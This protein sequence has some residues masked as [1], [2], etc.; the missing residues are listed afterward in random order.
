[1]L[2][3]LYLG[4]G[5]PGH[6]GSAPP[7]PGLVQEIP[8]ADGI[9]E[10]P[11]RREVCPGILRDSLGP[12]DDATG[13]RVRF[14]GEDTEA[15]GDRTLPPGP[16][17]P[18]TW[19]GGFQPSQPASG[20]PPRLPVARLE[21]RQPA[22][23]FPSPGFCLLCE[24]AVR[25]ELA[26]PGHGPGF[27]GHHLDASFASHVVPLET[28]AFAQRVSAELREAM[29]SAPNLASGVSKALREKQGRLWRPEVSG[30]IFSSIVEEN[31][32]GGLPGPWAQPRGLRETADARAGTSRP[33]LF[34]LAPVPYTEGL[35]PWR[36]PAQM[37]LTQAT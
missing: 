2:L 17:S 22:S 29:H 15:E 18:C 16:H 34:G 26:S 8:T 27:S 6:A 5:A 7:G 36:C 32:R 19:R 11:L 4:E 28:M 33:A 3:G 10:H 14:A 20:S 35:V 9:R 24:A 31:R 1:M 23:R 37:D 30:S 12:P 13:D 21:P 25:P